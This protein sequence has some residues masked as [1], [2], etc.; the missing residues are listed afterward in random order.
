MLS[1][2]KDEISNQDVPSDCEK[3][4]AT[5]AMLAECYSYGHD[6]LNQVGRTTCR[7]SRR[8]AELAGGPGLRVVTVDYAFDVSQLGTALPDLWPGKR[9]GLVIMAPFT[10]SEFPSITEHGLIRRESK[11]HMVYVNQQKLFPIV[12]S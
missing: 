6:G 10:Q 5:M 12:H 3:T 2:G 1:Q 4:E 7:G 11:C 9:G 8:N